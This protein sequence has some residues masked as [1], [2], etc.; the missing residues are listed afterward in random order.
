[1]SIKKWI[2]LIFFLMVGCDK[3]TNFHTNNNDITNQK[4][5]LIHVFSE[6]ELNKSYGLIYC[7]LENLPD[8]DNNQE[9][10]V[11]YE[12]YK[13]IPISKQKYYKNIETFFKDRMPRTI[14]A[15]HVSELENRPI[16]A[17]FTECMHIY[18][19]KE[20]EVFLHRLMSHS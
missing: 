3:S 14:S 9:L 8:L 18:N 10:T 16:K 4:L 17:V 19:S 1:M 13:K 20:Y 15:Y 7:L 2:V 5:D 11:A 12:E 6:Q